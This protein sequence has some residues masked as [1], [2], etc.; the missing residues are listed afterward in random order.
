MNTNTAIHDTAP[1]TTTSRT[2][3]IW[4]TGAVAGVAG[5]VGASAVYL[6]ARAADVPLTVQGKTFPTLAFPQVTLIATL[7]GVIIA[8]VV[9]RRSTHP[10]RSFVAVT[11]ALTVVSLIP[12]LALDAGTA[13]KVT[14]EIAHLVA[15]AIIIPIFARALS[16]DR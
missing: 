11:V 15:A 12:P 14:L 2:R 16:A 10:R 8:I 3:S 13:T 9:S 6:V 1:A 5:A 7:I 4:V